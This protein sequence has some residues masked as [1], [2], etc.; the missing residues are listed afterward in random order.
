MLARKEGT[1]LVS[2]K[3]CAV[4]GPLDVKS[5]L[6]LQVVK[7][8]ARMT[9]NVWRCR[10]G[11]LLK[12][13][14]NPLPDLDIFPPACV[15]FAKLSQKS[16]ALLRLPSSHGGLRATSKN[17]ANSMLEVDVEKSKFNEK[18]KTRKK[19]VVVDPYIEHTNL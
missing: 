8:C 2:A 3:V 4:R 9:A 13:G 11:D 19:V 10:T 14:R 17:L 6:M 1:P 15:S 18:R 16:M 5:V 7:Q 12:N